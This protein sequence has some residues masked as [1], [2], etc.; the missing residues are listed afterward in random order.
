MRVDSM[1]ERGRT[2]STTRDDGQKPEEGEGEDSETQPPGDLNPDPLED[3]DYVYVGDD[4]NDVGPSLAPSIVTA[5]LGAFLFGYHSA[6]INA[7]LADI[8]E[9]LG[10]GGDNVAKGA[11]VS[12]MVVGGFAGGL[13][14]GPFSDKEGR[15]AALVAT[16]VPLALGT[17]ICGG[18]NSFWTMMLG[19][20]VTGAGVGASTQI[21]PVYLSEVSP[22]GLRGTV[23]GIRRMGYVVGCLMAFQL[24]GRLKDANMPDGY[25][26]PVRMN[27]AGVDTYIDAVQ[28]KGKFAVVAE[29]VKETAAAAG[30][31]VVVRVESK[32][33]KLE[34]KLKVATEKDSS[35][36][37]SGSMSSSVSS[38][39]STDRAAGA[40]A[41]TSADAKAAPAVKLTTEKQIVAP[42]VETAVKPATGKAGTEMGEKPEKAEKKAESGK[43]PEASTAAAAP[44]KAPPESPSPPAS[45]E[46]PK[47]MVDAVK[48]SSTETSPAKESPPIS[49]ST[50]AISAEAKKSTTSPGASKAEAQKTA[51]AA[52]IAAYETATTSS[53]APKP[54]ADVASTK[55][56]A[57]AVAKT[58]SKESNSPF[59]VS[60]ESVAAVEAVVGIP[61]ATADDATRKEFVELKAIVK[62]A[63]AVETTV[64]ST[65][66][67]TEAKSEAKPE[68]KPNVGAEIEKKEKALLTEKPAVKSEDKPATV[69]EKETVKETAVV[70]SPVAK[71]AASKAVPVVAKDAS[72][73]VV[74]KDVVSKEVSK[75]VVSKESKPSVDDA[76]A[77]KKDSPDASSTKMDPAG[78]STGS[79]LKKEKV[80]LEEKAAA[81]IEEKSSKKTSG[82]ASASPKPT[83]TVPP[84]S[85]STATSKDKG[86]KGNASTTTMSTSTSTPTTVESAKK[87]AAVKGGPPEVVRAEP[88][89][90]RPLFYVAA[91]PAVAQAAG[92]LSGVAV[93]SPVWLLGPEG[94]AMESR[95][96]LAK[97]L[98][99]RGR[100]AV[101]L[102]L[103]S[104]E[105]LK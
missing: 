17:L 103:L 45:T 61:T 99:I 32:V 20:F 39:T 54:T 57:A 102:F 88:G 43:L 36:S 49:T 40:L 7:P 70:A 48:K 15:R 38:S 42:P 65:V 9:D 34:E 56:A 26:K 86:A 81:R 4:W 71:D 90:W 74:S 22:P 41:A 16:T 101:S 44:T 104:Y 24:C 78:V 30:K 2:P 53:L 11:I 1:I 85:A 33:E 58:V 82:D 19:R 10:F 83:T 28:S 23:N 62:E 79:A 37:T 31:D 92:A 55:A 8:A 84:T 89:W 68:A 87:A 95:R 63:A 91:I 59:V 50:S 69:S 14:I 72:K 73:D 47:P 6:V 94:C 3:D 52:A 18:A 21:V 96:S 97:L 105:Q 51:Y 93:E 98:G 12:I 80:D 13:G 100:A 66:T 5:C 46:A 60:K 77:V 29:K 67:S 75:E 35:L 27:G 25:V 64:S 76:A